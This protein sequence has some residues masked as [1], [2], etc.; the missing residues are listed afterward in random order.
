MGTCV[1]GCREVFFFYLNIL[2][3]SFF[4]LK[5]FEESVSHDNT[6][7]NNDWDFR[8][9]WT[10]SH[11]CIFQRPSFT[12]RLASCSAAHASAFVANSAN[13]GSTSC[14]HVH[15]GATI[16]TSTSS[17]TRHVVALQQRRKNKMMLKVEQSIWENVAAQW[18]KIIIIIIIIKILNNLS[19]RDVRSPTC[20]HVHLTLVLF[21][22]GAQLGHL[23]RCH[24]HHLDRSIHHI[25][26]WSTKRF[27]LLKKKKTWWEIN[28]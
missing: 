22:R 8:R 19:Y 15:A 10:V 3:R 5:E 4:L 24:L 12:T 18:K 26:R 17:R 23:G 28:F 16:L 9:D 1:V 6:P 13:V 20:V 2:L 21:A 7:V 14:S 11:H 25:L 27:L